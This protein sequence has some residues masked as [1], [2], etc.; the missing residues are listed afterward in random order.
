[1][2]TTDP[3]TTSL[4]D[5]DP[6]EPSTFTAITFAFLATPYFLDAI[7]PAQWVPKLVAREGRGGQHA[8][9]SVCPRR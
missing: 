5:P 2:G 1:M 4:M 9:K 6:F 3:S 8:S 7:V